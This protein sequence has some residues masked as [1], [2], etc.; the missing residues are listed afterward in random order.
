M[1]FPWDHLAD[2]TEQMKRLGTPTIHAVWIEAHGVWQALEGCHRLRA[3]HALGLTPIIIPVEYSEEMMSTVLGYDGDED[4]PISEI[5]DRV[6]S[7]PY[8]AFDN[9]EGGGDA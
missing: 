4:Y 5:C 9:L 1:I 7:T 8:L 6:G 2:V 3:A